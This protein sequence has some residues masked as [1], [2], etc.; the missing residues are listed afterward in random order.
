MADAQIRQVRSFN[1]LVTQTIGALHDQYLGRDRPVG[2][3]RLLFEIGKGGASAGELRARLDLDSGYVSRLLRSL[4]Q[5]GLVTTRPAADDKRIREARLTRSGL[6][7]LG[8]LDRRSDELG[9][10][11][12]DPLSESQRERLTQ[13]M[14]DVERLLSASAVQIEQV[15]PASREAQNCLSRYFQELSERFEDGFDPALSLA[16][17][18]REFMPPRGIFLVM[19]LRGEAVGCGGFKPMPPDAVYLKRMWIAPEARGLGLGRHLLSALEDRA[20]DIACTFARLETNKSLTEARRLYQSCGYR[21][22]APFN[23]EPYADHWFEK[24]LRTTNLRNRAAK[25]SVGRTSHLDGNG[26]PD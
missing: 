10:S 23:D 25:P 2:E 1:R 9:Q 8:E 13:A 22:V 7:E 14:Q 26:S 19:R 12:L 16:A 18:T 17:P 6:A 11:I 24:S 4:E 20:R 21:E 5:Q 3:S 15:S